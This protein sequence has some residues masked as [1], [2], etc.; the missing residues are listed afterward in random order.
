MEFG[1]PIDDLYD[2]NKEYIYDI[3]TNYFDNPIMHKIIA[4]T[5]QK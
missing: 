2:P 5:W 4:C 1:I 3:I